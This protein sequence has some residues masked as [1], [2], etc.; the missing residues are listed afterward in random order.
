MSGV[1]R[2]SPIRLGF[3]RGAAPS[4]W[5]ER[6]RA[7]A[8][9]QRLE[10]VPLERAFGRDDA[11]LDGDEASCDV[12]LERSLPGTT[13]AGTVDGGPGGR[14]HHAIRLYEE[15]VALV[16]PSDHELAELAEIHRDELALVR[17][18]DHPDHAPEWPTPEPWE[19]PAW[20]PADLA[21]ALA[22]VATGLGGVL[23]PLPL[24][25][26]LAGK[27]EHAVIRLAEEGGKP[28]PGTAVW[29]TW[30]VD[31]DAPDVQQLVGIMRGR[32]ARSSR[33]ATV[34][35]PD[36]STAKRGAATKP[37]QQPRRIRARKKR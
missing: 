3:T 24:A 32:T 37:A 8:N 35:Q 14:T 4:K 9:G 16:L 30:R 21:A 11:V 27:R 20:M 12:V 36:V 29:A 18:L 1:D 34:Q 19:D 26:H 31:R 22:L 15:A 17:L 28:L 25:R 6:W 23:A 13:P 5:A 33:N 10:L 2:P 7:A